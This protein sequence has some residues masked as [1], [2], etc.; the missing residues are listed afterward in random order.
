MMDILFLLTIVPAY[1]AGAFFVK[2]DPGPEEPKKALQNAIKFG[3]LAIALALGLSFLFEF[4]INGDA[5]KRISGVDSGTS[6]PLFV[7]VLIFATIEEFVKFIP[8][9]AYILRKD[10]FNEHTDGIIYFSIVGLTFGGVESLLYGL[11]SGDAGFAVVVVRLV[12]GLF[13]HGALTSIVG[14]FLISAKLKDHSMFTV[15]GALVSV[16]LVHTFYNYFIYSTSDNPMFIFGAA[17][18]ALGANSLMFWLY[19]VG[20]KQD[21]AIGLAGD[22]Y[23]RQKQLANQQA[24]MAV[25]AQFTNAGQQPVYQQ[26]QVQPQPQMVQP[27]QPQIAPAP[28]PVQATV[29][30][31]PV[32]NEG[33]PPTIPS[34]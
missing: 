23:V 3:V 28:Q 2:H 21:I 30:P 6:L 31:Q 19:Y 4:L 13:F 22:R 12:L 17:A 33:T 7:D 16:S 18:C 8:L 14:Y 5:L 34:I 15:V 32:E 25:Q 27:A 26:M 11:N 9:A 29:Q 1:M 10:Y 24:Q 20:T